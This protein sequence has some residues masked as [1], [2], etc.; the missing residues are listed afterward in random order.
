MK[1]NNE[2]KTK[3]VFIPKLS[4]ND[5][6]LYVAVNGRR[7]LVKK[8]ETVELPLPF[9]EVIENSLAAAKRAE[10]FIEAVSSEV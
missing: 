6:S 4:K 8:G 3:A 7:I 5:D 10:S 2:K 9:A 1:N